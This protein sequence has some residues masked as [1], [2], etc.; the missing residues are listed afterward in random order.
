MDGQQFGAGT[1]LLEMRQMN[2]VFDLDL[3]RGTLEVQAGAFWPEVIGEYLR[4]Q[5]GRSRMWGLGQKQTGADRLS[6]GGTL[7][8]NAHG[9][10]LTMR[11]FV[12]DVESFTLVNAEGE[13]LTCSRERNS[14]RLLIRGFSICD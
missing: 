13:L 5:E 8:A 11:P 12:G 9:R 6:I 3:N 2:Q 4:R 7:A 10:G 1:I 14:Q